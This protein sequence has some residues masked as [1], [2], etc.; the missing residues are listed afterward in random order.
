MAETADMVLIQVPMTQMIVM[1]QMTMM[2]PTEMK[3]A[4][5]RF[6]LFVVSWL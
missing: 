3:L 4:L 1:V 6:L 2:T 5:L